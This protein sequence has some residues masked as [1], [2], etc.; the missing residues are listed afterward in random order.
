MPRPIVGFD[1]GRR[2]IERRGRTC[3][4]TNHFG[5]DTNP[6]WKDRAGGG[7]AIVTVISCH[8]GKANLLIGRRKRVEWPRGKLGDINFVTHCSAIATT[9]D[10]ERVVR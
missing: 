9:V 3:G 7:A 4:N 6:G 1:F 10:S 8:H 2:G 5:R